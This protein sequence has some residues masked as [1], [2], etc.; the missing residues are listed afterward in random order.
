VAKVRELEEFN[1]NR[2]VSGPRKAY[3]KTFLEWMDK[4]GA[5][6]DGVEIAE[7]GDQGNGRRGWGKQ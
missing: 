3:I 5:K 4:N 6:V 7:F 1:M 2:K